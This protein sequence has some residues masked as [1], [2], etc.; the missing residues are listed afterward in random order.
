MNQEKKAK[1]LYQGNSLETYLKLKGKLEDKGI[2][3]DIKS[4]KKAAGYHF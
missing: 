2:A 3:Y 4:Q 1:L